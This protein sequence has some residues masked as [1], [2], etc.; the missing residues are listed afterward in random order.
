MKTDLWQTL[1]CQK[2]G[3]CCVREAHH[4]LYITGQTLLMSCPWHTANQISHLIHFLL[5]YNNTHPCAVVMD[6]KTNYKR[7]H[8][9]LIYHIKSKWNWSKSRTL[10]NT[11]ANPSMCRGH[12]IYMNKYDLNQPKA[13]LLIPTKHSNLCYKI[14]CSVVSKAALKSNRTSTNRRPP[15]RPPSETIRRSYVTS[16][17]AVSVLWWIPYLDSNSSCKLLLCVWPV[18]C[19]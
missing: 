3:N 11:V 1:V 9:V 10:W 16:V 7:P 12:T 14:L 19:V 13:E 15:R 17:K 6:V 18:S 8:S 2:D 4:R 5:L